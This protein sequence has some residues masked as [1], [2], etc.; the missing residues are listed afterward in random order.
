MLGVFASRIKM[1]SPEKALRGRD[2]GMPV[3]PEHAVLRTPL[4]GPWPAGYE[5]AV[6]AL[7][8]FWGEE[9]AFW[10]LDGVYS[11]AVGYAGGFTP[12]PTYREVCSGRT[13]HTESVLVVFDP[14]E[15]VG[16]RTSGCRRADR[17]P[18][19]A[20]R[21]PDGRRGRRPAEQP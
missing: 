10:S 5:T 18:A 8:C 17:M 15:R 7:G 14:A 9:K 13:G 12:N 1:V 16:G 21:R 20:C 2:T 4:S 3:P 11:T 19:G 6:F